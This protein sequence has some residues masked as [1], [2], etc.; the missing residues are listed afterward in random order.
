VR[1]VVGL[2]DRGLRG[3]GAHG[4]VQRALE[5]GDRVGGFV[6]LGAILVDVAAAEVD[7]LRRVGNLLACAMDF[8]EGEDVFFDLTVF[9]GEADLFARLISLD[10]TVTGGSTYGIVTDADGGGN[11]SE[12]P[13]AALGVVDT[14]F[15][16]I[17]EFL[18][19]Q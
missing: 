6:V 10:E 15:F 8:D 4:R 11:V 17:L 14:L 9:Q 7:E 13:E 19:C 5:L 2:E 18:P 3:R 16:E 1:V 12:G